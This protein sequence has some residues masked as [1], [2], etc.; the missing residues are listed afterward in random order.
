MSAQ[1]TSP[2][3]E[4]MSK[5]AALANINAE[6]ILRLNNSKIQNPLTYRVSASGNRTGHVQ[7][8]AV[9][10]DTYVDPFTL[11][12]QIQI[13]PVED[14]FNDKLDYRVQNYADLC[15]LNAAMLPIAK[16]YEL[17]GPTPKALEI[18]QLFKGNYESIQ[19]ALGAIEEVANGRGEFRASV[20]QKITKVNA[21][22]DQV[23]E[24]K[25]EIESD[26]RQYNQQF[27]R[28]DD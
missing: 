16:K 28:D 7:L 20:E 5:I 9:V 4:L 21:L 14:Y 26:V 15:R 2:D 18:L 22:I 23:K 1:R 8:A 11:C 27:Q 10:R 17:F 3:M 6:I 24:L 12:N 13:Q 19:I 25:S